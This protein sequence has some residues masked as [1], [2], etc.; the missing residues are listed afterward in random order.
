MPGRKI[1][2]NVCDETTGLRVEQSCW[3][4]QP[5]WTSAV[6]FELFQ[7]NDRTIGGRMRGRTEGVFG[8]VVGEGTLGLSGP[9]ASWILVDSTFGLVGQGEHLLLHHGECQGQNIEDVEVIWDL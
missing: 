2:G 5:C 7:E 4:G 6:A 8:R 9:G 3:S 1:L